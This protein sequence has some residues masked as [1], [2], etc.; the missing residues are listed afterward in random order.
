MMSHTEGEALDSQQHAVSKGGSK[1]TSERVALLVLSALLVA[2]VIVIYRVSMVNMQTK[3]SLQMLKTKY[4]EV[5]RHLN[6]DSCLKCD[7]DWE[8]LRGNCYYFS[9]SYLSWEE[10]RRFCQIQGGDLVKIDSRD[11]Q[12]F[13]TKE[14]SDKMNDKEDKFWI[15]LTDS[16]KEGEWFWVDDS[17]LNTSL[18]FWSKGEPDNWKQENSEGEDCVRMGRN[19]GAKNLNS[20]FDKSCN[21]PHKSICEKQAETGLC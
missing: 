4:E 7:K 15:G 8:Q 3:E 20:W 6:G 13:L 12:I 18:S 1:V 9:M 11:E 10:S 17:P 5:Q 2:A 14:L 16:K 19:G 21:K